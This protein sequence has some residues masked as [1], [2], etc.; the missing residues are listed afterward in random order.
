MSPVGTRWRQLPGP[1]TLS[2][3][4]Y[5]VS[6]HVKSRVSRIHRLSDAFSKDDIQEKQQINQIAKCTFKF[7]ESYRFII[8]CE[9]FLSTR[10]TSKVK[11]IRWF[12]FHKTILFF[13]LF[14]TMTQFLLIYGKKCVSCYSTYAIF[15]GPTLTLLLWFW[16]TN[17][18]NINLSDRWQKKSHLNLLFYFPTVIASLAFLAIVDYFTQMYLYS[19]AHDQFRPVILDSLIKNAKKIRKKIDRT[20]RFS[21]NLMWVDHVGLLIQKWS[22]K[23]SK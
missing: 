23:I 14:S 8:F 19:T 11:A 16:K 4:D 1:A 20:F 21:D 17:S 5:E 9:C 2:V 13:F 15:R 6:S 10:K 22:Q 12:F 7:L 3:R 18:P